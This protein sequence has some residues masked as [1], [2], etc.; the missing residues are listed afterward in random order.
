MI[1]KI[2]VSHKEN[3]FCVSDL[4]DRLHITQPAVSQ[5]LKVLKS[6]GVVRANKMGNK[7]FY[8]I[9]VDAFVEYGRTSQQLFNLAFARCD[10]AMVRG[11]MRC[12]R[13][14]GGGNG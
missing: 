7:V 3:S 11:D 9:D 2:L 8:M 5:H 12:S 13:C 1:I 4:A 14:E 6:V 10:D